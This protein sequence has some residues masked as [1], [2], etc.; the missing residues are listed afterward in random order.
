MA[1]TAFNVYLTPT[2]KSKPSCREKNPIEKKGWVA[3]CVLQ[4]IPQTQLDTTALCSDKREVVAVRLKRGKLKLVVASVYMKPN[5]T[6]KN[7]ETAEWIRKLSGQADGDPLIVGGDFNAQHREWGYDT[8]TKKGRDIIAAMQTAGLEL[9]NEQGVKT[10]LAKQQRQKDTT[11]DLTWA[12]KR[13]D[14]QWTPRRDTQGSDHYPIEVTVTHPS[15]RKD[16]ELRPII[17]WDGFREL[18]LSSL[19]RHEDIEESICKAMKEARTHV[20][21]KQGDPTPDT[22]LLNLWASRLQALT[23]FRRSR[24]TAHK[25]KLNK[26]TAMA[27]KY[28]KE[29]CRHK[30]RS[31]C[32]SFNART[33]LGKAWRTYRGMNKNKRKSR[34]AAQN[35]ALRL[36]MT[37]EELA[38]KEGAKR[39]GLRGRVLKFIKDFLANRRFKV[40]IRNTMGPETLNSRGVP[41][42]AVISPTLF[43]MVMADLP[44]RLRRIE[45]LGFTIYADDVTLWTKGGSLGDQEFTMQRGID[46]VAKYLEEVGM[47]PSPE[48]TQYMVV[49]RPKDHRKGIAQQV[50][51]QLMGKELERRPSIKILGVTFEETAGSTKWLPELR[52]VW[53]QAQKL[54]RR[55]TSKS[56]GADEKAIR[57]MAEALLT[58]RALYCYNWMNLTKAQWKQIER[59]NNQTMRVVT[60][61]PRYTPLDELRKYARMNKIEEKAESQQIAHFQRIERT[62]HGRRLLEILGYSTEGRPPIEEASPPWQDIG[63]TDHKP[64]FKGQGTKQRK[65]AAKKHVQWLVKNTECKEIRYT[66]AAKDDGAA[67]AAFVDI[68]RDRTW[69]EKLPT[70]TSVKEA[71]LHAILAAAKD[72]RERID[73]GNRAWIF[74]DSQTALKACRSCRTRSRT[75]KKIKNIA[76]ELRKL[77][78]NITI[79]WLPGHNDIPGNERA[80]QTAAEAASSTSSAPGLTSRVE[81][82]NEMSIDPDEMAEQAK[83]GRKLYLKGLLLTEEDPIPPGYTRWETVRLR[84]I[85]TGTALTPAKKASFGLKDHED[86]TCKTCTEGSMA[87]TKHV[88]WECKGLEDFRVESWD[89]LPSEKRPTNLEDWTHP[90]GQPQHRKEILDSLISY[91]RDSGVHHFI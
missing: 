79:E 73:P 36:K 56:W 65:F 17:K 37:E 25:I 41:Q 21:V 26:A 66:D 10:R 50:Q 71:E 43:N 64:T 77:D 78:S 40:K 57:T 24:A 85:R 76:E 23:R 75:V 34:N 15:G 30:W 49:A 46:E 80:H 7:G 62:K 3:V 81:T 54:I 33:G 16:K 84:R 35:L 68:A 59:L 51:L 89:S 8:K 82:T 70:Q 55:T 88:L 19:E 44:T 11:P 47:E 12:T 28:S 27:M 74:T 14:T 48:K 39:C 42:G 9:R 69:S 60:G 5:T 20:N 32:A 22:H 1:I 91:I 4:N 18:I 90:K 61:L 72:I 6:L 29:L 87:T 53:D 2:I 83:E 86:P 38:V 67:A 63:V 31:H 58:S 13:L 52:K 45:N